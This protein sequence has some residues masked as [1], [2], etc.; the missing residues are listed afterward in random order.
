LD[1]N[2]STLLLKIN[3]VTLD[4]NYKSLVCWGC[5]LCMYV[6]MHAWTEGVCGGS[7]RS[8]TPALQH[9]SF[10]Q[11]IAEFYNTHAHTHTDDATQQNKAL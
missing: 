5:N 4:L 1:L 3:E 7:G 11:L 10:C 8:H 2:P 9:D 6:C